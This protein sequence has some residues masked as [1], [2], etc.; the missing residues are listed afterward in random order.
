MTSINNCI[1]I[2]DPLN[3]PYYL[4]KIRFSSVLYPKKVFRGNEFTRHLRLHPHHRRPHPME[5]N[6]VSKRQ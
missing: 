3:F 1:R 2:V 6:L 4:T 5:K